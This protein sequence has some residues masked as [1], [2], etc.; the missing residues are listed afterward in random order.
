M[1]RRLIRVRIFSA[2]TDPERW[3]ILELKGRHDWNLRVVGPEPLNAELVEL[4]VHEAMDQALS[5]VKVHFR[6]MNPR[7]T[8]AP[9]QRWREA[10]FVEQ[11]AT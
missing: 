7:V 10:L 1:P 2:Q 5:M 6:D 8:L 11:S 4:T 9:F 3:L